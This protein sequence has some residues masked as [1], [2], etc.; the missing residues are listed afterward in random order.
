MALSSNPALFLRLLALVTLAHANIMV[1]TID[2]TFVPWS[3]VRRAGTAPLGIRLTN[4]NDAAYVVSFNILALFVYHITDHFTDP[5]FD[6]LVLSIDALLALIRNYGTGTPQRI[7]MAT[8]LSQ[9]FILVASPLG[10]RTVRITVT[11]VQFTVY[12]GQFSNFDGTVRDYGTG[13]RP[14][15]RVNYLSLKNSLPKPLICT[16]IFSKCKYCAEKPW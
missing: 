2:G 12:T 7:Q 10:L 5:R 14:Y 3:F 8:S 13:I 9:N 4:V 1:E 6:G 16:Q 15:L 11:A